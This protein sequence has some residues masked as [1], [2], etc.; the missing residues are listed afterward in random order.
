[1]IL[2][3][4][5]AETI[6]I[7][8]WI[9][10]RAFTKADLASHLDSIGYQDPFASVSLSPPI[11]RIMATIKRSG[12]ATKHGRMWLGNPA[13]VDSAIN[14]HRRNPIVA[15]HVSYQSVISQA[16]QLVGRPVD[17]DLI[18]RCLG[19]LG[20]EKRNRRSVR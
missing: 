1:M 5:S 9:R 12:Y 4:G 17:V 11:D 20:R 8:K 10:G 7:L 13:V 16:V 19:D 3:M 14:S 6:A 18:N 2:F 15:S